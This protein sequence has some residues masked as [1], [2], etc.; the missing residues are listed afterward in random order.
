MFK[1]L[2]SDLTLNN[3]ASIIISLLGNQWIDNPLLLLSEPL[4]L[5]PHCLHHLLNLIIALSFTTAYIAL[6][7]T[8][9]GE[10]LRSPH[11]RLIRLLRGHL[12]VNLID[13]ALLV[14]SLSGFYMH[15]QQL[16]LVD[17]RLHILGK[18]LFFHHE[19]LVVVRLLWVVG[20]FGS[21]A[22]MQIDEAVDGLEL[23]Q[24][25]SRF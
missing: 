25:C 5:P 24:G 2:V 14:R 1:Q 4:A 6:A 21:A 10:H 15:L 19:L 13:Y 17:A 18:F 11:P 16:L 9:P 8:S 12:H 3:C 23:C 20:L 22:K 7:Y